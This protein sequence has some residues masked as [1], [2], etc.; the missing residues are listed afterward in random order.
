M[1]AV[2]FIKERQRMCDSY[3]DECM[4]CLMCGQYCGIDKGVDAERLVEVVEL[5]SKEHPYK[6][7]Q[8]EYLKQWPR[9][10]VKDDGII[11]L[12]PCIVSSGYRDQYGVCKTPDVPC[13]ECRLEFW[14]Q[15][16]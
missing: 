5:W 11:A 8:S 15:G 10:R 1:D 9:T 16:V 7:R 3:N 6:T 12:C 13:D 4:G 14:M 2:K